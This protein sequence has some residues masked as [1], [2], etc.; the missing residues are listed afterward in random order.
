MK[1]PK[2]FRLS[3]EACEILD[4]Q[5]NATQFIE[6]LI[7][8]EVTVPV[9]WLNLEKRIDDLSAEIKKIVLPEAKEIQDVSDLLNSAP[10]PTEDR[11]MY[12]NEEDIEDWA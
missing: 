8:G 10:V 9:P 7:L 5:D 2:Q 4:K 6:D 12:V 3:E 1:I 11:V